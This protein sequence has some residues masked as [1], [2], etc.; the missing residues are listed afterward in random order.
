[1]STKFL[2]LYSDGSSEGVPIDEIEDYVP[3]LRQL[4]KKE[5]ELKKRKTENRSE[6][7]TK[8]QESSRTSAKRVKVQKRTSNPEAQSPIAR[9]DVSA[10][11]SCFVKD[12]L[13]AL[14][15][16][17]NVGDAKQQALLATLDNRSE[18]P[19][20]ALARYIEEGGLDAMHQTLCN[21]A[22]GAGDQNEDSNNDVKAEPP[23]TAGNPVSRHVAAEKNPQNI[24]MWLISLATPRKAK[25]MILRRLADDCTLVMKRSRRMKRAK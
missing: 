6:E 24:P 16:T 15:T 12:M 22:C 11:A 25:K 13:W 7:R 17:Y 9:P 2:L 4:P 21:W 18:Q 5:R 23:P 14:T 8:R 10:V 20:A 19:R 1:M 3:L